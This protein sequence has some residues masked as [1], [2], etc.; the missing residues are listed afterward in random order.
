MM[1]LFVTLALVDSTTTMLELVCR[2]LTVMML[3]VRNAT[4]DMLRVRSATKDITLQV[5]P[6]LYAASTS[7]TVSSAILHLQEPL[8]VLLCHALGANR[9]I[10]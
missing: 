6:A 1:V 3:D 9:V 7:P 8:P 10:T 2:I 4:V 5:R